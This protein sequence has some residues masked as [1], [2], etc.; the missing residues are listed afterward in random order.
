MLLV[1]CYSWLISVWIVFCFVFVFITKGVHR[2]G[3]AGFMAAPHRNHD[4]GCHVASPSVRQTLDEM[5]FERGLWSAALSGQVE[6][7]ETRLRK[8]DDV[9]ARDKSGYTALVSTLVVCCK[10]WCFL[11]VS[12]PQLK[13]PAGHLILDEQVT[14]AVVSPLIY[15]LPCVHLHHLGLLSFGVTVH[16]H[17]DC[18]VDEVMLNVL[19]CRL[20]Y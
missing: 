3:T 18:S 19:R 16:S 20:T 1:F 8:G 11:F 14:R 13:K 7:I 12:S 6:D 10:M 17:S 9:N 4:C 5:E 2:S 15:M